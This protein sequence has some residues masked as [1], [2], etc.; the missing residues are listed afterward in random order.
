MLGSKF[1]KFLM[2]ILKRQVNSSSDFSSFFSVITY[3][4]SVS[5]WL[6]HFLLW[7]KG[8]HK[9]TSFYI[10][11]CSDENLPNASSYFPNHKSVF[12]QIFHDSSV[13]WDILLC[14]FLGQ[15]LYTLHQRTNQIANVSDFSVL[16]RKFTKFL[17]FLKQKINF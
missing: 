3:N 17:S 8:S 2:S 13:S 16:G 10:F 12:L 1:V 15:T 4:S 14:T 11:K 5:L 7:T 6:M 9:N